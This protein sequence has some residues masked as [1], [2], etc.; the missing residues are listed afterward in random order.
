MLRGPGTK[1]HARFLSPAESKWLTRIANAF[2]VFAMLAAALGLTSVRTWSTPTR[3]LAIGFL[4]T[5]AAVH[6][7][8]LGGP[9]FH[10]A[11]VPILALLAGVGLTV[12]RDR[13]RRRGRGR[14]D[15][16]FWNRVGTG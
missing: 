7:V 8:F 5:F 15:R 6:L 13:L 9:R 10:A 16:V 2:W 12:G 11:E 1:A 3:V 4:G 14:S